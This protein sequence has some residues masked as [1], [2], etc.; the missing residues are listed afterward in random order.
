[1]TKMESRRQRK[2]TWDNVEGEGNK[3]SMAGQDAKSTS[4]S[5]SSGDRPMVEERSKWREDSQQCGHNVVF[6]HM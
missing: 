4:V 3:Y 5:A 2:A 1:M 6:A